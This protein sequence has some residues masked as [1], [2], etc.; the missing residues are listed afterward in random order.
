M[1]L[2]HNA[3][4]TRHHPDFKSVIAFRSSVAS[5]NKPACSLRTPA[6][7]KEALYMLASIFSAQLSVSLW[8]Y[9]LQTFR[10]TDSKY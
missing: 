2:R 9:P 3:M 1:P 7:D 6:Q 10:K 4:Q 8:V 5:Y